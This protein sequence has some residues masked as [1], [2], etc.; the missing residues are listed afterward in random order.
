MHFKPTFGEELAKKCVNSSLFIPKNT[1]DLEKVMAA[2]TTENLEQPVRI[3]T[4]YK[5]SNKTHFLSKKVKNWWM[6]LGENKNQENLSIFKDTVT[7]NGYS[8]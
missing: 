1:E 8:L 4:D 2:I 5:R 7:F 6:D 3:W